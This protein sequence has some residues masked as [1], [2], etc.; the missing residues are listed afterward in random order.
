VEGDLPKILITGRPGAGKTTV[1]RALAGRLGDAGVRVGGILTGE[2]REHG[3]RA[4][5]TVEEI[6][7]PVALMAHV[8]RADGPQVGRYRVDVAAFERIAL[9]AI[10]RAIRGTQVIVIDEVGRMEL[11]SATFTARLPRLLA[12]HVPVIAS[13]H[14]ARH[15]VTDALATRPGIEVITVT[16][17]NRERLPEQLAAR[18]LACLGSR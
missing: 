13:M 6:G 9:P 1:L 5:F 14:L 10:D 15:P 16:G 4:G 2:V 17:Q 18:L 8:R 7:G 3:Q 12:W 11:A